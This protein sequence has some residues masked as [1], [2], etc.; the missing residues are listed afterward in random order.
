MSYIEHF[1]KLKY[2]LGLFISCT[3]LTMRHTFAR[4]CTEEMMDVS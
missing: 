2:A 4:E 3:V 1:L